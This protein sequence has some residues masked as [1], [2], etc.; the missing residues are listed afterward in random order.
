LT[1]RPSVRPLIDKT[2]P[3]HDLMACNTRYIPFILE[4]IWPLD[5]EIQAAFFGAFNPAT[6]AGGF[7]PGPS[8]SLFKRL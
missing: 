7:P 8:G 2:F 5:A 4:L 6:T 1:D 3:K